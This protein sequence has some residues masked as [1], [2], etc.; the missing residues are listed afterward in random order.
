[1]GM[2]DRSIR[3]LMR[4]LELRIPTADTCEEVDLCYCLQE[5]LES[6]QKIKE[7]KAQLETITTKQATR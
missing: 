2:S 6:R 3:E 7:L 1:M 5:L 4:T